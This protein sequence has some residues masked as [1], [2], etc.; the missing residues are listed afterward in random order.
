[1][2]KKGILSNNMGIYTVRPSVQP[3][4]AIGNVTCP[5]KVLPDTVAGPVY[6]YGDLQGPDHAQAPIAIP[7]AKRYEPDI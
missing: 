6:I 3:F 1:M 7:A 4:I 2:G 5:E